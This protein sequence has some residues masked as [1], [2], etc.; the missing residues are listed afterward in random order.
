[1]RSASGYIV[2][3]VAIVNAVTEMFGKV[4]INTRA[5][6]VDIQTRLEMIKSGNRTGLVLVNPQGTN[7]DADGVVWRL[8]GSGGILAVHWQGSDPDH[9]FY[10]L[11]EEA[12]YSLDPAKRLQKPSRAAEIFADELPWISVFKCLGGAGRGL[13][14]DR[15]GKRSE[16]R[17]HS[18]E[19]HA[20][21]RANPGDD[22]RRSPTGHP[23]LR[24]RH[25]RDGLRVAGNRAP[26][27][28]GNPHARL[29]VGSGGR[30]F[31]GVHIRPH[32]PGGRPLLPLARP[33]APDRARVMPIGTSTPTTAVEIPA[34]PTATE[35]SSWRSIR[36]LSAKPIFGLLVGTV[37]LLCT[38]VPGQLAPRSPTDQALAERLRPPSWI[39][40]GSPKY[41]L[42]TDSLWRD[43]LSR[44]I[45][46]ART[47]FLVALVSSC[48]GGALGSGL[49]LLAG[50][51]RGRP[52]E[53]V[54]KLVDMQ[55]AF[56]YLLLAISVLAIAGRNLAVLVAVLAVS[57]WP[58]FARIV[59]GEVLSLRER[60]FVEAARAIGCSNLWIVAA[61]P[62]PGVIPSLC[63]VFTF[64]FARVVILESTLS[65]L[66]LGVQP[67]TQSWGMDLSESRQFVQIAWLTTLFPGL[68]ISVVVFAANLVGDWVRD[69]LDPVLRRSRSGV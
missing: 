49:G 24:S 59:R 60:Q 1:M 53:I 69:V 47:T 23:A 61:H 46:G 40:R 8:I 51:Y 54:R 62:L 22:A 17:P 21:K 19:A 34:A 63:V 10:R 11:M 56:P 2:N 35:Q 52:D 28:R 36:G 18:L 58:T 16:Y 25:R 9:E 20:Q 44:V 13:H 12:R 48:L 66:G 3:D 45:Y 26:H 5:E 30:G 67:P 7:F 68:A 65:F 6:I 41:L 29:S 64:D 39:E 14:P 31:Y 43:V 15:H 57:S 50:Y 42:G 37:V 32:E 4:G 55:L 33:E 38:I 27:D